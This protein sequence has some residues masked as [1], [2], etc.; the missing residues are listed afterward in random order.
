MATARG[1]ETRERRRGADQMLRHKIL[2]VSSDSAMRR[3]L[4]RLMTATGAVTDF[5]PDLTKPP[6]DSPSLMTVDLRSASAPKLAELE[7]VLPDTRVICVV[8]TQ[9]F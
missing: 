5:V 3:S 9:D 1:G 4:K 8:G 6:E 2:I 7:Q